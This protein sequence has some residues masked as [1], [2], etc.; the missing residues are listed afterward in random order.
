VLPVSLVISW[1]CLLRTFV[2]DPGPLTLGWNLSRELFST[3]HAD[4]NSLGR[5]DPL[6]PPHN[7]KPLWRVLD[8]VRPPRS[9]PFDELLD[10]VRFNRFSSFRSQSQE[11]PRLCPPR[12]PHFPAPRHRFSPPPDSALPIFDFASP[13]RRPPGRDP[14][15]SCSFSDFSWTAFTPPVTSTYSPLFLRLVLGFFA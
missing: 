1:W 5:H 11:A 9:T 2:R 14:F 3:F 10:P 15:G 6:R 4:K 13:P 8:M 7:L 12:P